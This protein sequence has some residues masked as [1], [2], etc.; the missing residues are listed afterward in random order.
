MTEVVE[1]VHGVRPGDLP[2]AVIEQGKRC[3]LD[4]LGVGASGAGTPLSLIAC[5]HAAGHFRAAG[6][7]ARM[8]YDG[9]RVSPVGAALA[10]GMTIDSMDGHDGHSLTKGH[11][12]AALLPALLALADSD[13]PLD[14]PG[15]LAALVIGYEVGIRAGMAL[16]TTAGEYHSSGAWNA[17]ASAGLAARLLRL[18]AAVTEHALGIAEYHAPRGPMMRGIDHPTMVKDSSGWGA[19]AGVSAALLAADGFT[20]APA[21]LIRD[22]RPDIAALWAD[23]GVRWRIGELYFKPHPV[24]RWAQP[25]VQA[26]LDLRRGLSPSDVEHAEVV[27]FGAAARL[28]TRRPASTEEAQYSLTFPVAAALVRGIVGPA[29]VGPDGRADEQ[30]LRLSESITVF[31]SEEYSA[32]FPAQRWSEVTVVL[33]DGRRLASGPTTA[34]GDPDNPLTDAA[35]AAKFHAFADDALGRPRSDAVE[36]AVRRLDD[37]AADL[38]HLLDLILGPTRAR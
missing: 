7:G 14:G 20:G 21:V 13:S 16:H 9:R 3:V 27:T 12:G 1:F 33:R 26:A 35:L 32:R 37:P 17:V 36:D 23:L 22:S 2:A 38:A 6:A 18:D 34:L 4:L 30:V 24:C 8:L 25:A 19:M 29:E 15:L 31:E 28:R 11:A 5:D 10:G